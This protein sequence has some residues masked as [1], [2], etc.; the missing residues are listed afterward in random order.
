MQTHLGRFDPETGPWTYR[1]N[2]ATRPVASEVI[3]R[4][5]P[6]ARRQRAEIVRTKPTLPE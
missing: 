1:A 6:P 3:A 4:T 2:E 5:N